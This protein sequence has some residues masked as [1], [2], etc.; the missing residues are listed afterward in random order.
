M[1]NQIYGWLIWLEDVFPFVFARFPTFQ[2]L[3]MGVAITDPHPRVYRRSYLY[4]MQKHIFPEW[5]VF[6]TPVGL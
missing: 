4:N 3:I 5:A 2:H 1:V 6:E